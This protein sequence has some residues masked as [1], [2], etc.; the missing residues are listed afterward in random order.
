MHYIFHNK[1][2]KQWNLEINKLA[3]LNYFSF[4]MLQ[5]AKDATYV[6][7]LIYLHLY[8]TLNIPCK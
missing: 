7:I 2:V 1:D 4:H 3:I 8:I 6:N 5:N